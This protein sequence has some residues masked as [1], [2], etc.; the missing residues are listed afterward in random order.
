MKII[1]FDKKGN[2]VRFY[3]GKDDLNDYW[4]DDWNDVPYEHNAGTVY[5]EFISGTIDVAF[6]FVYTIVEPADDWHYNLNSPFCKDDMR[7]RKVPCL[8]IVP[9]MDDSFMDSKAFSYYVGDSGLDKIYFNDNV[10]SLKKLVEE[11]RA[12]IIKEDYYE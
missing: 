11:Q 1:D 3:L 9:L 5:D 8:I 6:P 10:E 12:F 7:K 4:G 2:V